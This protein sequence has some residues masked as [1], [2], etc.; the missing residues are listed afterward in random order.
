LKRRHPP[1]IDALD[2]FAVWL[3]PGQDVDAIL[4]MP[5]CREGVMSLVNGFHSGPISLLVSAD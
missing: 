2:R 1:R 3:P 5:E 4:E